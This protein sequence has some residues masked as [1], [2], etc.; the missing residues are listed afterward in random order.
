MRS[1]FHSWSRVWTISWVRPTAKRGDHDAPA[2]GR[3]LAHD[4]RQPLP[5]QVDGLVDLA[6]VGALRDQPVDG[7]Q[8][9]RVAQDG[10][11][12]VAEVAGK[13]QAPTA[14]QVERHRG[15]A[16]DVARVAVDYRHAAGHRERAVIGDAVD[17]R[18]GALGVGLGVQ[19]LDL[20]LAL[21]A[22]LPVEELGVLLLDE[23]AVAQHDRA[24]V[25]RG[26]RR[27]DRP[28]EPVAPQLGQE[29]RV[30]DVGV[31]E[32]HG[33]HRLRRARPVAVSL[34]GFGAPAL[35][36]A[37]VQKQA[38]AIVQ[39]QDVQRSGDGLGGAPEGEGHGGG[40]RGGAT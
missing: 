14:G 27:V 28:P 21:L 30:V 12:G 22:H 17:A 3:R 19:R 34:P 38:R 15:R 32:Q 23:G 20:R 18:H 10:P 26:V 37:A 4:G 35:V 25:A 5:R 16:Q 11:A 40:E 39:L 7:R 2:A 24:Q 9:G 13:A 31:R 1:S 36:E 6:A 29:P 33:V 8:R